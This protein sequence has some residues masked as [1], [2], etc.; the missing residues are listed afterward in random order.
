[1]RTLLVLVLA[2]CG[3]PPQPPAK[4][5]IERAPAREIAKAAEPPEPAPARIDRDEPVDAS[6]FESDG[7]F[8]ERP[9]DE[10]FLTKLAGDV[11]AA[12]SPGSLTSTKPVVACLQLS[13]DGRI[14]ARRLRDSSGNPDLDAAASR[15]LADVAT[16]R[17]S[18]PE[19][20]PEHLRA[21]LASWLCFRLTPTP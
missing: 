15:A 9:R 6:T 11:A 10:P 19:P 2:A 12:W 18:A 4:R 14:S 17:D 5:P 3:A 1:M 21:R 7:G 8:A 16:R 13:A 20:V